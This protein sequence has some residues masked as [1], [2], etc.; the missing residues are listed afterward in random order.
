MKRN[1]IDDFWLQVKPVI[2]TMC[3]EWQGHCDNHGYGHFSF[4]GKNWKTHI[5]SYFLEHGVLGKRWQ[6]VCHTCDNRKCVNPDHLYL[7]TPKSN[8]EDAARRGR[9]SGGRNC[10]FNN[11]RCKLSGDDLV[12]I[13]QLATEGLSRAAIGKMFDVNGN[14]I[15]R[16]LNG[17]RRQE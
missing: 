6:F 17:K 3:W 15:G 7:G 12:K 2:L 13:R 1:T 16:I 11:H 4:D 14:H 8:Q 9:H 10:G 5:L